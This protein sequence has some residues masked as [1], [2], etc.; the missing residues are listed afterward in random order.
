V[1]AT[2]DPRPSEP[3]DADTVTAD[4]AAARRET[5]RYHEELYASTPL[6]TEGTWLARPHPVVVEAVDL[7]RDTGPVVAY[8]LGAGVGRHAVLLASAL[9]PGSRVVAVDLLPSAV[10]RLRRNC[11]SAGVGAAVTP[12]VADLESY[13][14]DA[15]PAGLVVAFSAIEHVGGVE[16]LRA[17]LA[18]MV[19]ATAPGGVHVLGVLA[20]RREVLA[21]GTVRAAAVEAP[22]SSTE[23]LGLLDDAY[24]GWEVLRRTTKPSVVREERDGVTYGLSSTLV[25]LLARRP[26]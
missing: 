7:V 2:D 17:L 20:D 12:V 24:A 18:R 10:D 1:S 5:V 19:A 22:L 6:G 25:H 14:F 16:A 3:D 15:G 8:D 23:A 4:V 21:D 11:R 9:A 26:G 13:A